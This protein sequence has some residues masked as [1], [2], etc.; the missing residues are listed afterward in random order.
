MWTIGY[1]E[2]RDLFKGV[3]PYF[4]IAVLTATAYLIAQGAELIPEGFEGLS[5]NAPYA[6]GLS[7][8]ILSFGLLFVLT[9]SH[10]S[11]NKEVESSTIRFLVTKASRGDII[12]GKLFGILAYWFI[13][14]LITTLIIS[15]FSERF[16]FTAF[17]EFLIF[18]FYCISLTLFLSVVIR[19]SSL[20]MFLGI[21]LA[22]TI[23][24]LSVWAVLSENIYI[25][26]FKFFTPYYYFQFD[27]IYMAIPFLIGLLLLALSTK[28]FQGRDF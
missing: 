21:I 8:S 7:A 11:V 17:L 20:S 27:F 3:R 16:F 2:F 6:A 5:T 22:F 23:P 1:R 24:V 12:M 25:N 18:I 14:L 4:L 15:Y 9:L 10:N 13:L 19:S 28:I 26:W